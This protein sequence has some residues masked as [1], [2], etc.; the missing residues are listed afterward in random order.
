MLLIILIKL[1]LFL[2][3]HNREA[4]RKAS[5]KLTKQI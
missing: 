2:Q 3:G 5:A 4:D 1:L